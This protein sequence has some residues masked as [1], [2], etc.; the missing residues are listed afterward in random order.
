MG[1]DIAVCVGNNEETTTLEQP[2]RIIV[3]KKKQGQWQEIREREFTLGQAQG[4]RELRARIAEMVDFLADCKV[5]VGRSITGL[6]YFE[7]EKA[8]CSVW[9]FDGKPLDFLDYVLEKE[10]EKSENTDQKQSIAMPAPE[11]LD[12]GCYRISIKEIQERD[13]GITSKQALQ[14]VLRQ[15]NFSQ[16]EVIC[17]HIPPW[18]EAELAS[19]NLQCVNKQSTPGE[20]KVIIRKKSCGNNVV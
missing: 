14:P 10:E 6:P 3:Y 16:L 2:G 1:R 5:F 15:L 13:T 7:L 18:L 19:G 9:E 4:V 20:I 17:N 8:D 11:A 12:N